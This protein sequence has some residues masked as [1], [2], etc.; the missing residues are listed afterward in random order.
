M[1]GPV[2]P[3]D[4]RHLIA[5]LHGCSG[6]ADIGLVEKALAA[7]AA[8]AGATLL[9][10]GC[11]ARGWAGVTGIAFLALIPYL[12]P[13]LPDMAMPRRHPSA[14]RATP[15]LALAFFRVVRPSACD[16]HLIVRGYAAA[17]LQTLSHLGEG[18]PTGS[19]GGEGTPALSISGDTYYWN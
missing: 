3:Y 6:L 8:A 5:E 17:L 1:T 16:Q 4:G 7:A 13:H 18:W 2:S 14:R 9:E 12:D 15:S 19:R 10:S 11:T